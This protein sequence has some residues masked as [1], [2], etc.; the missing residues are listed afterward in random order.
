MGG[1]EHSHGITA[2]L[3]SM[4]A[5]RAGE[6]CDSLATGRRSDRRAPVAARG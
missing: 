5:V 1:T 3:L 6:I 4:A 2:N